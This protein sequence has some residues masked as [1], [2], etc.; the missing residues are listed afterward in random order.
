[1]LYCRHLTGNG[2]NLLRALWFRSP[3]LPLWYA[4]VLILDGR[5]HRSNCKSTNVLPRLDY[6]LRHAAVQ[7]KRHCWF[8]QLRHLSTTSHSPTSSNPACI[9]PISPDD[10]QIRTDI[11]FPSRLDRDR[12][13]YIERI[14]KYL[15][16]EQELG[17][18]SYRAQKRPSHH[19]GEISNLS[20]IEG[21]Q[22]KENPFLDW[23]T[24]LAMLKRHYEPKVAP[25]KKGVDGIVRRVNS[26]MSNYDLHQTINPPI[27]PHIWTEA[28]LTTYIQDLADFKPPRPVVFEVLSTEHKDPESASIMAVADSMEK[29]LNDPQLRKYINTEACNI[30]LQFF[31]D[32][33]M[34][35][36]AR[37]L[38]SRMEY[39]NLNLSVTTW[40]IILRACASLKDLHNFT[41][42]LQ[43]MIIR[44]FRPD[45]TTWETFVMVLT[46]TKAKRAV[47]DTI[48]SARIMDN[49]R[50]GRDIATQMVRHEFAEHR[51]HYAN[52]APFFDRMRQLYGTDWVS[53]SVGNTIISLILQ[54]FQGQH[55]K[56]VI[57]ALRTLYEMKQYSFK[58]NDITMRIL[59]KQCIQIK[60]E[61]LSIEILDI[62]ETHWGLK[63][64]LLAHQTLFEIFWQHKRLNM[65]RVI[66]IS[67]CFNGHVTFKMQ[68]HVMQ[69]LLK[70][71]GALQG[72]QE[73]AS[74]R[75]LVGRFLA[76]V[77]D[78]SKWHADSDGL[79]FK[80]RRKERVAA[81]YLLAVKSN[82]A[83]IGQGRLK[84]GLIS[85][86]RSALAVDEH[87]ASEGFWSNYQKQ[88]YLLTSSLQVEIVRDTYLEYASKAEDGRL[89]DSCSKLKSDVVLNAT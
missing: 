72:C 27:K 52:D 39:L 54:M 15:P 37:R 20:S 68:N 42:L 30:A 87:W 35:N 70:S 89:R 61:D 10:D 2:P 28:A 8:G 23:R 3:R 74:F 88:L 14:A 31:Y 9:E 32:R 86:L 49:G 48:R 11:T 46:S 43:E 34:M 44:G 7:L 16:E 60:R 41:Y 59:L 12:T 78:V 77:Q 62:F 18:R 84:D 58:A 38:Y 25:V 73:P 40:N 69:S 51:I 79:C 22:A 63:P 64:G 56:A 55:I 83:A 45:E 36:R 50:T 26:R 85:Q 21:H 17:R 33:S 67:A 66:W 6:G 47:V 53:T 24:A 57:Q 80:F 1:M 71:A 82:L 29:T 4:L 81:K 65:L 13:R 5:R 19:A 75:S 76:G